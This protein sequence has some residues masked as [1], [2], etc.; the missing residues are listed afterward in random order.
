MGDLSDQ[1]RDYALGG[2]ADDAASADPWEL[3]ATWY[4]EAADLY[5]PNAMV[6]AT[7][8]RDS[9]PDAR[10][11][12]LKSFDEQG[13]VFFTQAES[14]KGRALAD[15]PRCAALF[16]WFEL[17]RQVRFRGVATPLARAEVEAYFAVRPRGSQLGAWA[18]IEAGGQSAEVA[19][20]EA[21]DAAYDAVSRRFPGEVPTPPTWGGFRIG[22][23][24]VEF[25][26]GRQGRM[27]DRLVYRRAGSGWDRTRLA[28]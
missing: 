17:Q 20:R 6:L 16:P 26:Q 19:G 1:R 28:P 13:L 3:F 15:N 27:H 4:A 24:Q 5:E 23:D 22:V 7:T 21:L 14:A 2:L 10:G 11:V 18:S 8:D 12:L 25:W 9:V